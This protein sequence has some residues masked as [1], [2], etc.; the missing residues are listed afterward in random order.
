MANY[1]ES[2]PVNFQSS[3]FILKTPAR[4]TCAMNRRHELTFKSYDR[5]FP[6]RIVSR[7]AVSVSVEFAGA[8]IMLIHL[9]LFG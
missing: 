6:I 5:F 9:P 4:L 1:I 8:G 7:R 3:S 2:I